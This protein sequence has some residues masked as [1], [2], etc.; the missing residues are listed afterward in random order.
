MLNSILEIQWHLSLQAN[1]GNCLAGYAWMTTRN[2]TACPFVKFQLA[3]V[4]MQ[5]NAEFNG[6]LFRSGK[7]I[8][9]RWGGAQGG[10][11]PDQVYRRH[12]KSEVLS[13]HQRSIIQINHLEAGPVLECKQ[14]KPRAYA[15]FRTQDC[16]GAVTAAD[17][18][19]NC[20]G[21]SGHQGCSECHQE[22]QTLHHECIRVR[23]TSW[24]GRAEQGLAQ[25]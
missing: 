25:G 11:R 24:V 2:S 1:C 7:G 21:I 10:S 3:A 17:R 4:S 16:V 8:G 18:P 5:G 9:T 14:Q 20:R 12:Q 15:A 23:I 22:P 6:V 13:A 19:A